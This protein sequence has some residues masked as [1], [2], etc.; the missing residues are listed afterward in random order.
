MDR[1]QFRRDTLLRWSQVNP[2]LLEGEVGYVLDD[3]NKYKIGDGVHA[4]NEL[5]LRG[6]NGSIAGSVGDSEDTV[7]SQ[8]LASQLV[9]TYNV[10]LSLPEREH[11]Y[12]SAFWKRIN[13]D[14]SAPEYYVSTTF[15]VG[16]K[17]N[18][19]DDSVY[20]YEALDVV[21]G[22]PPY[23]KAVDNK[24]NLSEAIA[25]L[26][27]SLRRLGMHICF[28]N[29]DNEYE[30]WESVNTYFTSTSGWQQTDGKHFNKKFSELEGKTYPWTSVAN[31]A[32]IG[33]GINEING[34]IGNY[35]NYALVSLLQ[36]SAGDK[37]YVKNGSIKAIVV[38]ISQ[39]NVEVL[40]HNETNETVGNISYLIY[41]ID[42]DC[43]IY[44]NYFFK[45]GPISKENI[46]DCFIGLSKLAIPYSAFKEEKENINNNIN[47]SLKNKLDI[48]H[49]WNTVYN[50]GE[51]GKG[52]NGL[53]GEIIEQANYVLVSLIDVQK[54]TILYLGN[55]HNEVIQ[56]TDTSFVA[57]QKQGNEE[58][59]DKTFEKFVVTENSNVY[60]N[61]FFR[62]GI[63]DAQLIDNY[64]GID[65]AAIP[66]KIIVPYLESQNQ[67]KDILK[68]PISSSYNYKPKNFG[69]Y[70]PLQ[71]IQGHKYK[72]FFQTNKPINQDNFYLQLWN[73]PGDTDL[74]RQFGNVWG[75]SDTSQELTYG[76]IADSNDFVYLRLGYYNSNGMPADILAYYTLID[77]TSNEAVDVKRLSARADYFEK[78]I[79]KLNK[80]PLDGVKISWYGTSIPAM[81]YPQ[82]VGEMTGALVTNECQGSSACRRGAKTTSYYESEPSSD[83]MRIKGLQWAVPVYGLMMSA[84]EKD[85]IFA[86]WKEY[87]DTWTGTYEGEEGA[88]TNAKPVDINDGE[89]EEL[90]ATLRDLCYDVRVARHLGI[91]HQYNTKP[92]DV[93]D[94][95]IIE[96]CYNDVQAMFKDTEEEFSSVPSNPYDVNTVIGSINALIKYIYENNPTAKILLIGHYECELVTGKHCKQ[97]IELVADYWK[98]PLLKLYDILGINQ[99]TITTN[100]Y[101]DS[102]NVWHNT[103]FTFTTDG[104]N[105]TSNNLAFRYSM[106]TGNQSVGKLSGSTVTGTN[107]TAL[108]E[109]LGIVEGEGTAKWNPTKQMIYLTD[110]LHPSA[111]STKEYFAQIISNWLLSIFS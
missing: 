96:H 81:G 3:P 59:F 95:Y 74:N 65:S 78:I 25:A 33:K 92:V 12:Y 98:I 67:L 4:W 73:S 38:C 104:E 46:K 82:L 8:K 9:S 6:F 99:K 5:P 64:V 31:I 108:K 48:I 27:V 18:M 111:T 40:T 22:I 97:A 2:V 29:Y 105:W 7:I 24:Y 39:G 49:F 101:W 109:K 75:T 36:C 43:D 16:D 84:E 54:D 68:Y 20:S 34:A 45:D 1:I 23:T 42:K 14:A 28:I 103:G 55:P 93:S 110:N 61:Y 66:Y 47:K 52:I 106:V 91:S 11:K 77:A 30:I 32:E 107:A 37:L 70:I 71:Q 62:Y 63:D 94:I 51:K 19:P 53:T 79:N 13:R 57:L 89:H 50:I 85:T 17:C 10:S 15:N 58:L 26:P 102:N 100:G 44:I 76:F 72:V 86:N 56:K 21:T 41:D 88:P 90:K 69:D 83:P 60:I 87:A 80:L 35:A